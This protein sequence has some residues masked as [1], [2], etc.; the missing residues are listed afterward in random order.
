VIEHC[1]GAAKA[2]HE[3]IY[4]TDPHKFLPEVNSFEDSE[5]DFLANLKQASVSVKL[6]R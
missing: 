2:H 4:A 6:C 5:V 3:K 1:G